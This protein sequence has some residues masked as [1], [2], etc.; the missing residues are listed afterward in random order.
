MNRI[1]R[2]YWKLRYLRTAAKGLNRRAEVEQVLSNVA[3]GK[4]VALSPEE[5][6]ALAVKLGSVE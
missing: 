2:M 4:R 5:C 6:R 3:S 1:I